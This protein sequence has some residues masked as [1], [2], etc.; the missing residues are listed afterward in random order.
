M[1]GIKFEEFSSNRKLE[2]DG[3]YGAKLEELSSEPL[4]INQMEQAGNKGHVDTL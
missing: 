1:H 2:V 4:Q 3:M